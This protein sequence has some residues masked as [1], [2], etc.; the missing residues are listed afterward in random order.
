[1]NQSQHTK[2]NQTMKKP[3]STEKAK[4]N[5]AIIQGTSGLHALPR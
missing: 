1:M 3:F 5:N 2:M 4:A